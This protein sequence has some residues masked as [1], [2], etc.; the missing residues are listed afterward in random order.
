MG[1][2]HSSDIR[3]IVQSIETVVEQAL[4]G[5]LNTLRNYPNT[6]GLPFGTTTIAGRRKKEQ[7]L[8]SGDVKKTAGQGLI[9]LYRA[10]FKSGPFTLNLQNEFRSVIQ[11][12]V[13][14]RLDYDTLMVQTLEHYNSVF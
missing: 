8:K 7:M 1:E 14:R 10:D 6:I 5:T 11:D 9:T 13:R 12:A 3:K 4:P 2:K